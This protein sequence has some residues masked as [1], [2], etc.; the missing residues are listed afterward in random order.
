MFSPAYSTVLA[1]LPEASILISSRAEIQFANP[2]AESLFGCRSGGL[3]GR[4]LS[5]YMVEDGDA[6]ADLVRRWSR[7][8][9]LTPAALTLRLPD[10]A[11]ARVRCDGAMLQPATD[12][13][14]GL[15][16]LRLT[17]AQMANKSFTALNLR[18][19]E[20][21]AENL[22]RRR[23][24]A[25]LRAQS[26]FLSV[27]L[28]SI[29]DAVITT[30]PEGRVTFM[31]PVAVGLTGWSADD[32]TDYP[33]DEIFRIV[34][35]TTREPVESPVTKVLRYGH[36]VGL[37]NHTT[38]IARDGTEHSID[39]SAAPIRD[40]DGQILGVVLVFHDIT[41]RRALEIERDRTERRKDEFLAMLGHKLRNPL[42]AVMHC[43]QLLRMTKPYSQPERR[44]P[45]F[46]ELV[47]RMERQGRHLIRL[48][49]DLLDTARITTGKIKLNKTV[50]PLRTV[51]NSSVD[52]CRSAL[53]AQQI[54]LEVEQPGEPLLVEADSSRLAQVFGNLLSNAIKYNYRGGKIRLTAERH[55]EYAVVTVVDDGIGIAR[56]ALHDVFEL[57]MQADKSIARSNGGL[58]VGLTV[59][60]SI[61]EMH[62]G[63]ISADSEGLGRGSTFTVRLP[64]VS[65]DASGEP[66]SD[67]SDDAD[68][69][70]IPRRILVVDDN[71]DAAASLAMLLRLS[72]H[73]VRTACDGGSA[74]RTAVDMT[75]D[76]VLLDVGLP[77][78]DGYEV[79]RRLRQLP[80]LR[81]ALIIAVTG[82]GADRDRERAQEAGF[83]YHLTKPVDVDVL[84]K[85][86]A[87]HAHVA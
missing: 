21:T 36:V 40:D 84:E 31:N 29:G 80:A 42:A 46:V 38:L 27:T 86:I 2:R 82:Y 35:E 47:E 33:L 76:V 44:A 67:D 24:E 65:G 60:K 83:N 3:K 7:S 1:T 54:Q 37:A 34:H 85:L 25:E 87:S 11:P 23:A 26:E 72:L 30:D 49:D 22:R 53:V 45:G 6:I 59:C 16:L 73:E 39:D 69:V 50:L 61:T 9:A 62:G 57:F 68:V 74:L 81:N 15:L 79:A 14:A 12:G 32:A 56:D 8:R 5:N 10:A 63:S 64:L 77:D 41:E 75:P 55:A 66:A 13:A 28:S 58:G 4:P 78:I 19:Q 20:L 17:P 48:V 18:I 70:D 43:V 52:M 51:I 71:A